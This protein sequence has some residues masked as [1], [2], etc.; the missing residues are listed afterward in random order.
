LGVDPVYVESLS[1]RLVRTNP[2]T[3]S[4]VDGKPIAPAVAYFGNTVGAVVLRAMKEAGFSEQQQI[5]ASGYRLRPPRTPGGR[6]EPY[7]PPSATDLKAGP[8]AAAWATGPYLHNGSVPTIYE[9]LSPEAER[10]AVFWTGG[11]ELDRERLG[12]VSD[13]APGRFRFDTSLPGN[14]NAGHLYPAGGL[15][16]DERL[17]II[18]YLKTQ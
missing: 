12:F 13:D 3:A 11:R 1:R 2:A 6:P 4:L 14:R 9:L 17:A 10:R 5:T 8:L 7:L 15:S 16:H 18:E